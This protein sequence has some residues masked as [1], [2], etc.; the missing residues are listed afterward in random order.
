VKRWLAALVLFAPL[1]AHAGEKVDLTPWLGVVPQV[2]DFRSYEFA[3][4][5]TSSATVE[6]V[7]EVEGGG[8]RV[9]TR[10]DWQAANV[11]PFSSRRLEVVF[12]G[13]RVLAA[14]YFTAMPPLKPKLAARLLTRL[15]G[16]L[17]V[18]RSRGILVVSQRPVAVITRPRAIGLEQLDTPALSFP[19][20]LRV[21]IER[22]FRGGGVREVYRN[23]EW[24][25]AGVGHV[26]SEWIEP[27]DGVPDEW[28]VSARIND[29][30]LPPEEP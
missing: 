26:A 19:S 4:G 23:R 12:P 3:D 1:P 21:D 10:N 8:W 7:S 30:V 22:V 18:L 15:P 24:Y 2:S 17:V 11:P 9:V 20:V 6:S 14:D 27:L 16:R 13:N 28:L 25:L 29:I 5:G